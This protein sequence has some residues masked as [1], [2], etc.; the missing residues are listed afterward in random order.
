MPNEDEMLRWTVVESFIKSASLKDHEPLILDVGSGR[1][2]LTNLLSRHGRATGLEP[3][4]I[5]VRHARKLF[6]GLTFV[7]GTLDRFL[8]QFPSAK[9]DLIVM[10]EVF[11]HIPDAHKPAMVGKLYNTL[12]DEG[13]VI[14]T[15]PRLEIIRHLKTS[16]GQPVEDWMTEQA[17]AEMFTQGGF[18]ESRME[19]I[20]M[21]VNGQKLDIYQA[22]LFRKV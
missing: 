17:L 14:I 3:V 6:P 16:P 5:V 4:E 1:G 13:H 19:R 21:S 20:P 18:R 15:T 7:V 22:W 10:S 11:E 9:V 12:Q 2:W 8:S